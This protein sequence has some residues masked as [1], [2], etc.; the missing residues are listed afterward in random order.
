MADV[1]VSTRIVRECLR[2]IR[3]IDPATEPDY[4]FKVNLAGERP[5]EFDPAS[6]EV[7]NGLTQVYLQVGRDAIEEETQEGLHHE[8]ELLFMAC[9]SVDPTRSSDADL[10]GEVSRALGADLLRCLMVGWRLRE[11]GSGVQLI[12]DNLTP[13]EQRFGVLNGV[14]LASFFVIA[15]Y[16][17]EAASE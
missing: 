13:V 10:R 17:E 8:L 5:E 14:C 9:R 1:P 12:N 6:F 16:S 15:K 11:G 7:G 4:N 2:R 3:L